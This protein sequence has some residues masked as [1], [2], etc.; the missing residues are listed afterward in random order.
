MTK[1]RAFPI[2]LVYDSVKDKWNK[3]PAIPKG[4]DWHTYESTEAEMSLAVNIGVII[5]DGVMV[6]DVDT[7]K[8]IK[9][10][11]IDACLGCSLDWDNAHVQDTPSGG[12]HY[13]FSLPDGVVIRQGSD[14]LNVEG[15]DTRTSGKGWIATGEKYDDITLTGLPGALVSEQWPELPRQAIEA[16]TGVSGEL[17]AD[18][19]LLSMVVSQPLDNLSIDEIKIYLKAIVDDVNGY[20]SWLK[21]GMA[22]YH[23]FEG[24][25][26]GLRL[27]AKWSQVSD[28]YNEDELNAKWSSFGGQVRANPI[29][30][31]H[32]IYRAG[33]KSVINNVVVTSLEEQAEQVCDKE[34]YLSF[35][36]EAKAVSKIVLPDDLRAMLAATVHARIGGDLGL[37]KTEVKK[38]ITPAKKERS[39][40]GESEKPYWCDDW[41]YVETLC[42]FANTELNY[43]IK[44]EAFNAKF[45]REVECLLAEKNAATMAL[46]DYNMETVVDSMYWPGANMIFEYEGKS[47]VN[48]YRDSGAKASDGIDDD[49]QAVI[50][51]FLR[52]VAFTLEDERERGILLDWLAYVVQN[53]GQRVS[54]ALLLQGSQGNGKSYFVN[55]LQ[56]VMGRNVSNLDGAA[57]A[58]RFTGWAHGSRV[59][60]VEEIRI[61]GANKYEVL[62]RMKPFISNK[63]VQIEEKG[64]DHRTVPNFTSYLLLTNYKDAIPI[65]KG[66]RRYC[67]LFSR[68]QSEEALFDELGGEESAGKHFNTLFDETERR[69]D[70]LAYYLM[71]Y[72]ISA[73]FN[74]KGRAPNTSAR[75]EMMNVAISPGYSMVEDVINQHE[76]SVINKDILD[77]TKLSELCNFEGRELPKTSALAAILLEM[78]YKQ[79]SNR[80]IKIKET[81][82][83][84]Y[85]WVAPQSDEN[86]NIA[87]VRDYYDVGF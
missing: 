77:I 34:T 80:R 38:A 6:I 32:V 46:V 42:Q 7:Y 25:N 52:H 72:K 24:N 36:D 84:H 82:R 66:D 12:S 37:T 78:G 44:R 75:D 2:N 57:I 9:V 18:D 4:Q 30:F 58:G 51:M 87:T 8:G 15:F 60:A 19:D 79:L 45:D 3:R 65:V 81:G 55:L 27:W 10:S 85:I 20:D 74:P 68:I 28:S 54:W 5:P 69:A 11:D 47:M 13:A 53:K 16:L 71:N 22:L 39:F 23:Q 64:R 26:E 83:N 17:A 14:L 41:V 62:D 1:V 29:T 67:V 40:D 49:G 63:T 35:R 86:K 61:S 21:V 73:D 76:C 70:V 48:G 59:V 31:A 43:T 50:D 56:A 33:G